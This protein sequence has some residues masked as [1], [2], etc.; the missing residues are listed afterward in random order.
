MILE[1]SGVLQ[2]CPGS[3]ITF[4]C[5]V[6]NNQSNVLKWQAFDQDHPNGDSHFYTT[7]NTG[8]NMNQQFIGIFTLLLKSMSPLVSTATLTN[9]FNLEQN[10]TVI[11]C[12]STLS[13]PSP[14]EMRE[15]ELIMNDT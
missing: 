2:L 6:D 15:A 10:G 14:S 3:N 12:A 1:P 13:L 8:V 11:V 9:G 5:T 4:V 7:F